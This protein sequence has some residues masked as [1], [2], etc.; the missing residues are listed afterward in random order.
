MMLDLFQDERQTWREE[1]CPGALVLRG[2][3]V[4]HQTDLLAAL[5]G[6]IA[7]APFR[8]MVTPGGFR[9]SVAMSNCGDYGWVSDQRGYRYDS[10]DPL[11]GQPWPRMPE[12][13]LTLV[14]D[15]A[16][17]AGFAGFQPDACLINRYAPGTRLSL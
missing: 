9:M 7:V 17:S 4:P 15:A 13:F 14:Q 10:K 16:A 3:A 12:V 6:I 1:L 11:T 2:F 8:H 5:E